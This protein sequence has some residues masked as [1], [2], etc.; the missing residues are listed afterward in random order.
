[1]KGI[2]NPVFQSIRLL[3]AK[4]RYI[5]FGLMPARVITNFLDVAALAGVALFGIMVAAGLSGQETVRFAGLEVPLRDTA[6]F[7]AV[8]GTFVGLFL[9][10][11]ALATLLLRLNG[12]FLARVE[13]NASSEVLEFIFGDDLSQLRRFRQDQIQWNVSSSP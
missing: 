8:I 4:Q 6:V 13:S 5:Y 3:T 1:M 9:L 10:K 2:L 7:L 11:S 12:L